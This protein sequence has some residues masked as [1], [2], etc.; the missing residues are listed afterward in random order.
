MA[1]GGEEEIGKG[2]GDQYVVTEDLTVDGEHSAVYRWRIIELYTWKLY[3][4]IKQCHPN[5]LNKTKKN[6]MS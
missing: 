5:K 1:T 3:N 6:V 2:K 4:F